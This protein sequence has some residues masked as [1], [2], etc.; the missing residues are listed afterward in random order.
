MSNPTPRVKGSKKLEAFFNNTQ[1]VVTSKTKKMT[2]RA[3]S[4][5]TRAWLKTSLAFFK[6]LPIK[7]AVTDVLIFLDDMNRTSSNVD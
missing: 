4:N 6:L 2:S 7:V 1:N 5:F 3:K